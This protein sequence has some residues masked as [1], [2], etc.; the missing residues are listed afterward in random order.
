MP[1]TASDIVV[2][3]SSP[4]ASSGNSVA[5]GGAGTNRGNFCSSGSLTSAQ[6]NNVFPDVTGDENAASNVDYQC[7]FYHNNHGSLTWE[8]PVAW[9]SA[10]TAGGTSLAIG[11]SGTAASAVGSGTAQAETIATKNTAPSGPSFSSPTTKGAGLAMGNIVAGNVKGLWV[12]RT[13][14]N[15]SA[16]NADGGTISVEGDTAA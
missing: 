1:I 12:R 14:A 2:K 4:G 11:V 8:S 5:N 7:I 16:L 6:D 10:E 15:T 9:I 3:G 13:A